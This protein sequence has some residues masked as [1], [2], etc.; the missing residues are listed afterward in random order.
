M[1]RGS[2]LSP[3]S[4]SSRTPQEAIEL[5]RI[6]KESPGLFFAG[7][8]FYPTEQS[9]PQTQRFFAQGRA[10]VG[11]RAPHRLDRRHAQ[12]HHLGKLAVLDRFSARRLRIR[13]GRDEETG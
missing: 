13:V 6:I 3:V 5:V 11:A 4:R 10:R 8:L 9:W 7:F 12:S 1:C 2:P